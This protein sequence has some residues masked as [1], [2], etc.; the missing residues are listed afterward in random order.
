LDGNARE[1]A[2]AH[3]FANPPEWGAEDPAVRFAIARRECDA[4]RVLDIPEFNNSPSSTFLLDIS[5]CAV[6][7][8]FECCAFRRFERRLAEVASF[9]IARHVRVLR[10][11]VNAIQRPGMPRATTPN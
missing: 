8:V 11:A 3:V 5:G 7:D 1:L 10:D 6:A 2:L 4:I 9:D